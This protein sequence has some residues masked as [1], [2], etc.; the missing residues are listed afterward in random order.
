MLGFFLFVSTLSFLFSIDRYVSFYGYYGRFNGGLLSYLTYSFLAVVVLFLFNKE[1]FERL[2][3]IS[4]FVSLVV[5]VIGILSKFNFDL[6]CFSFTGN[7]SNTC[8]TVFFKPSERIFSTIGQPNWLATYLGINLFFGI[9]FFLKSQGKGSLRYF[10]ALL[11]LSLGIFFTRSTSGIGATLISLILFAGFFVKKNKRVL[12]FITIFFLFFLGLGYGKYLTFRTKKALKWARQMFVRKASEKKTPLKEIKSK[13]PSHERITDSFKIRL[14]VWKGAIKLWKKYP[15]LGTGIDTFGISYYFTRPIEHNYTSEWDYLYNK[16]HNEFLNFLA[17]T[18]IFGFFAYTLFILFPLFLSLKLWGER[19]DLLYLAIFFAFLVIHITDFF[20]FSTTLSNLYLFIL[21]GFL[22]NQAFE[23]GKVKEKIIDV[24]KEVNL[25]LLSLSF[26]IFG[27]FTFFV[28]KMYLAD[29]SYAKGKM[30]EKMEDY[31]KAAREYNKAVAFFYN[32]VYGQKLAFSSAVLYALY[33]P[34]AKNLKINLTK[35][36]EVSENFIKRAIDDSPYN[37]I[38]YRTKAKIDY[39]FFQADLDEKRLNSAI[40]A[41]ERA[42]QLAPTEPRVFYLYTYFKFIKYRDSK[43]KLEKILKSDIE[44]LLSLKED[45]TLAHILKAKIIFL[46]YG[47]EKAKKY[48]LEKAKELGKPDL[49]VA[50][51]QLNEI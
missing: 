10:I 20:G 25:F 24:P 29:L 48:L 12:A 36:K 9:Y 49:K 51:K 7:F 1:D 5:A 46:L 30:Y 39:L 31:Y 6:L 22:V 21:S 19:Q 4:F 17:T 16:A 40:K 18:G 37:F 2:L 11:I 23:I 43:P 28:S 27:F 35:F 32:S 38:Y 15:I 47:K 44:H 34:Y 42:T 3:K 50:I 26:L 33:K 45:Y 41:L 8:W 14:I 13:G